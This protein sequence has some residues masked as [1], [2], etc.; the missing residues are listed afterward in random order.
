MADAYLLDGGQA[1]S[2]LLSASR[3]AARA[4]GLVGRIAE[5]VIDA[6]LCG[7]SSTAFADRAHRTAARILGDHRV[8]VETSGP[9]PIGPVV[10]VANHVSYLDPLVVSSVVPCLSVAKGEIRSWPLIG[11][12]MMGLG[13]LFVNRGHAYS[14]AV[15]L[16]RAL[17][18]LR[19]GTAV[20]NFPEG[21]TSDGANVGPFRRG[22]FGLARLAGVPVVPARVTYDDARVHWFGG[23]AFAPHYARLGC[24]PTLTATIHF[25]RPIPVGPDD[26]PAAVASVAR[27]VVASLLH[28]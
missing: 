21:T 20:L 19:S 18:A 10:V 16:R 4:L 1:E 12:G 8:S 24:I 25:G 3:A 15:V 11:R 14:G 27:G 23:A 5:A 22:A 9:R 2:T 28:P 13:V 26:D 6:R 17:R 7:S